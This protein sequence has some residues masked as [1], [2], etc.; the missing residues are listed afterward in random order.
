MSPLVVFLLLWGVTLGPA[1]E[2]STAIKTQPSLWAKAESLL[3]P[4][5]NVTL[6]CQTPLESLDFQLLK[7]GGV[8]E[9]AHVAMPTTK[10]QFPLGAVTSDSKGLYRCR[11]TLQSPDTWT[12]L[13][14]L[15]EVTGTEPLPPPSLS[16][17]PVSWI[18]PGLNTALLCQ[19]GLQGVTFLLKREG[20]DD[21]LQVAEAGEGRQAAFPISQPGNYSC[22][23]RTA[24]AG[25]SSEPSPAVRVQEHAAPPKPVLTFRGFFPEILPPKA[26]NSLL[27][28]APLSSGLEFQ[29]RRGEEVLKVHMSSTSPDRVMFDMNL[30]DLGDHG[31][32][33]CRY[34]LSSKGAAWSSDSSPLEIMWSDRTLPAPVLTA[35]PTGPH[36]EP[37]S[38]VQLRCTA[39]RAGLRF[40]L[41]RLAP[42]EARL[43]QLQ[44]PTGT[45]AVFTL[46]DVSV[47]DSANYSCVYME[48]ARPY[49]GSLPSAPL[50]LRV[51]GPAPRPQLQA[52]WTG[53]V[54]A[55]RDAVLRCEG[56]VPDVTFELLREGE[57]EP[58][59]RRSTPS[60]STLLVL[61]FVGP[62]H[63]GKYSC[64]YSSARRGAFQ[65]ELSRPA[66]LLV[67]GN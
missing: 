23:Y 9:L 48:R 42:R 41:Q 32:F 64:R 67:R 46:R 26:P 25:S 51:H 13:S 60:N 52:L 27:C 20:K 10:Y 54:P 19:A 14:D 21:F 62:Q 61:A 56:P 28:L 43:L 36:P 6:I 18:T 63:A 22:S 65:S 38:T 40:A 34:R 66:E 53:P 5:A 50:E 24:A 49:A 8:Q 17:E 16:P 1:T 4:W 35:A 3:E 2:A 11:T 58:S 7:D 31:P 37:G 33:T 44:S 30:E 47:A 12:E 45:Q 15:L 39:A 55:G 57:K 29:L 59:V